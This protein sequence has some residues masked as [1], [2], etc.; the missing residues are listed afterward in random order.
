[1]DKPRIVLLNSP[2]NVG[3]SKAMEY[4]KEKGLNLT[5]ASC[6]EPLHNP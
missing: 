6:K 3:K 1:M 4:M 5:Y 2:A